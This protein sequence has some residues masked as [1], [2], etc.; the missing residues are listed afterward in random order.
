M[1]DQTGEKSGQIFTAENVRV[2]F[3]VV[4]AGTATTTQVFSLMKTLNYLKIVNKVLNSLIFQSNY[5][6]KIKQNY[7]YAYLMISIFSLTG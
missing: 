6:D 7:T 5:L 1:E 4:A 3:P 2:A